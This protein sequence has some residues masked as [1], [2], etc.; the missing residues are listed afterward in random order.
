MSTYADIIAKEIHE[1]GYSYGETQ[2]I[3]DGQLI[4]IVD[5][6]KE[7]QKYVCQAETKLAALMEL[8]GVLRKK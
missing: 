1:A 5:A 8:Q 6:S 7:G 4:W 3:V 2:A